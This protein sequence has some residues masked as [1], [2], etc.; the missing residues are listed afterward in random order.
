MLDINV[1]AVLAAAIV[2]TAIATMW[3]SPHVVGRLWQQSL[4]NPAQDSAD[5]FPVFTR[6]FLVGFVLQCVT[7]FAVA[8]ML[9]VVSLLKYQEPLHIVVLFAVGIV[10]MLA[11]FAVWERKS[12]VYVAINGLYTAVSLCVG[13]SIILYWPW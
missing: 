13:G 5:V 8:E 1:T 7:F 2:S 3:Y 9:G 6:Q 12:L 11:G 4:G 10:A